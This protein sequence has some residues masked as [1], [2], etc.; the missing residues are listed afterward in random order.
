MR[1]ELEL[2]PVASQAPLQAPEGLAPRE[3]A[4]YQG[5]K[6]DKRRRE[7]LAARRAAKR[8]ARRVL[9]PELEPGAIEIAKS[10]GGA[11][12]LLAAGRAWPLSLS[13]SGQW[14]AA[15][16]CADASGL[17][18]VD[19]ERIEA[20]DPSWLDVAFH[21]SERAGTLDEAGRTRLWARKEAVSKLLGIGLSADLRHIRFPSGGDLELRGKARK[22]WEALGSPSISLDDIPAL[23]GYALSVASAAARTRSPGPACLDATRG[24][25]SWEGF[26]DGQ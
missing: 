22:A 24:P 25:A 8:L 11:P 1:F 18:G 23:E 13:H 4:A 10:Q 5:L 12:S 15:A 21:P 20:R 16:L 3:A 17:V 19:L 26:S 9:A 6:T 2:E 7:W 14:A